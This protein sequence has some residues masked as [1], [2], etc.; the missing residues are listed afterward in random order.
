MLNAAD[1][2]DATSRT[3]FFLLARKDGN[4]VVWPEPSHAKGDVGMF[5]GRRPW[6]GAR[7]I[8]DWSNPAGP[9]WTTRSTSRSH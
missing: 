9:C 7:E 1:Y 5:P 6:R 8:I 4:P 2:G 3:R